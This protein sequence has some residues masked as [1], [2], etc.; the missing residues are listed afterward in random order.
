M[1]YLV[2]DHFV[3][4][5]DGNAAM[6]LD[7]KEYIKKSTGI[8][9]VKFIVVPSQLI[10]QQYSIADKQD[11]TTHAIVVEYPWTEVIFLQRGTLRTRVWIL[12]DF[13]GGPTPA[14]RRNQDLAETLK[15]T[16]RLLRSAEAAKNRAY[17]ELEKERQQQMQ[18]MT[19]KIDMVRAVARAR[20]KLD[21]EGMGME[22][23]MAAPEG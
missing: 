3:Y 23:E 11:P 14:S 17:Q 20:G 10:E 12:T 9:F 8:R 15:D 4:Y 13:L 16:E 22:G 1:S 7:F 19:T 21:G 6:V 18:A 5:G 2:G